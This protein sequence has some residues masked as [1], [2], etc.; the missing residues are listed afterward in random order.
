MEM[1]SRLMFEALASRERG[2]VVG[3]GEGGDGDGDGVVSFLGIGDG[4][5]E[6]SLG[7]G[8]DGPGEDDEDG[9]C[10]DWVL[11]ME[12]SEGLASMFDVGG[13]SKDVSTGVE[14]LSIDREYTELEDE[15]KPDTWATL[16]LIAF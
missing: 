9:V 16:D 8:V 4:V 1:K 13:G 10:A 6:K 7:S 2:W 14:V 12:V 15:I 11:S 3:E 5:E